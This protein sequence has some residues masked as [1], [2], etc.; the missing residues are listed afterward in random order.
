VAADDAWA[1]LAGKSV[2]EARAASVDLLRAAGAL[3]GE[4]TPITH[5][6]KFYEK[7]SQPLEITTSRQWFIRL[8]EHRDALL[9]LGGQLDWQPPAMRVRYENWVEGLNSDWLISRQRFFGVPVPLWYPVD[10]DGRVDFQ[11][12]LSPD[13]DVLPV[14]P[15]TDTPPGYEPGQ[16]GQPGGFVGDPDV[17]DTWATSSLTPQIAGGWGRDPDLFERVFPMDLRPQS[18]EIIRTWLFYTVVRSKFEHDQLP[19]STVAISGWILDPDRKKM[20]KSKGNVVTPMALLERYGS[21]AIRYWAARVR[22]G[23]DSVLDEGQIRVG[24]R[25]AIKLLNVSRFVLSHAEE[26]R[27]GDDRFEPVDAAMLSTLERV[28]AETTSSLERYDYARALDAGERFFW[29][30]CDDY[31][32]LVKNRAYGASGEAGAISA[33]RSLRLA[34]AVLVR[35]FA[36]FLP[37]VSEEVWSWWQAG[38]VHRAPWPTVPLAATP[39]GSLAFETAAAVLAAVRKTKSEAKCSMRAPVA[40][41]VVADRPER[42]TALRLAEDDLK[43]AGAV[44]MVEYAEAPSLRVSVELDG[45]A[46]AT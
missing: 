30:F 42:L 12:P 43:L 8:L 44:A 16:R 24:R 22:P 10:A 41:L 18:H 40:R 36:P 46:P 39:D 20:S 29:T 1:A 26:A 37:F 6:V 45:V 34:L 23:T 27:N 13:K 2:A 28:V 17:M 38:S 14:D 3:V 9:A 15:S 4:P 11:R 33:R 19:W 32:E 31:V 25:L 21:D 35:L 7:G 5:P